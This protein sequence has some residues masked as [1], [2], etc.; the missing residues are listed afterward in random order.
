MKNCITID[1][2]K[3]IHCGQCLRDCVATCL[4]FDE[5]R[6]P[7]YNSRADKCI[8]CQH[9]LAICP[10]GAFSFGGLKPADSAPVT[11]VDSDALL[12]LIK[13]RR[14]IRQYKK[15]DVP[16]EKIEQLREMLAYPPTGVNAPTLHFTIFASR[17]KMDELRRITYECLEKVPSTSPLAILKVM[18]AKGR[19]AGKDIVYRDAPAL[20]VVSVDEKIANAVCRTVDPIIALSYVELYAQSLGLGTLW[21]GYAV[22]I[23]KHFP[24]V[25]SAFQ[26]PEHHK[27]GFVMTLGLPAVKYARS[28]QLEAKNVT[29]LK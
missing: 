12:G 23:A 15:E 4:E 29:I 28:P 16:A 26:L 27:L 21:D 11:T 19:K 22:A 24:E 17:Q 6:V 7:R 18:A 9:C 14:S 25:W 10:T 2:E 13:S 3:C 20:V 1:K 5:D 8:A